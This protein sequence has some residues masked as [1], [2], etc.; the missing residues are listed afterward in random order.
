ML[1]RILAVAASAAAC[2]TCSFPNIPVANSA[3]ALDK[4]APVLL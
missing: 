4:L 3:C 1:A 2:L